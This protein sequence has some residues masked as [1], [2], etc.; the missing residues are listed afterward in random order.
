[1]RELVEELR[2]SDQGDSTV[3]FSDEKGNQSRLWWI[4]LIILLLVF[5]CCCA[6]VLV[7][8]FWLGDLI[9]QIL[10]NIASQLEFNYY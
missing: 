5:L 10:N 8:Y 9:L 4:L 7:M 6:A 1:L 3:I 2:M